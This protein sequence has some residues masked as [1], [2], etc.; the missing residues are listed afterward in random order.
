[1][2]V[3]AYDAEPEKIVGNY[4]TRD[5]STRTQDTIQFI[6]DTF[7]DRRN[8]YY[9]ATNPSGALIDGLVF[10]DLNLNT[11][12]NAIW[13]LRTIRSETGWVSEFAIHSKA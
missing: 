12:W 6:L 13:E 2:G 4:M 9:F 5:A 8:A 11:D 3:V 10:G 1:M 7:N